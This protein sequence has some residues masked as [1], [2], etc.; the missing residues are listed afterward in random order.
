LIGGIGISAS[1][2]LAAAVNAVVGAISILLQ[3]TLPPAEAASAPDVSSDDLDDAAAAFPARVRTTALIAYGLSSVISFALEAAWT[4]MLSLLPDTSISAFVTMLSMVLIGIAVGSA[5][6][7]T[8]VRKK[9]NLPLAFAV[10]ELGIAIGGIWA[11]WSVSN[12]TG[13]HEFLGA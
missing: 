9:I 1:I 3:R 11:I 10:L 6:A 4:R 5:L 2:I 13:L 12:L 8:L 7:T